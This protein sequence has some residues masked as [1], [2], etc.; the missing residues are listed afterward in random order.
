MTDI[1]LQTVSTIDAIR[2]MI[3]QDIYSLHFLPGDKIVES[4]LARRYGVSRNTLREAV[5]FLQASGILMKVPNK[6]V[7]V[8]KISISDVQQIFNLRALLECEAIKEIISGNKDT[9]ILN[10]CASN[11]E[12]QN[13][14]GEWHDSMNADIEFH[15]ML[16]RLSEN[17]R[18]QRLYDCV[19]PE[20]KL[21]IFQSKTFSTINPENAKQHRLLINYI[22][23]RAIDKAQNILM[24]HINSA[25]DGYV[26]GLLNQTRV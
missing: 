12:I 18:L 15:E 24:Y 5:A 14:L 20:V 16:I 7:F 21:C 19:L 8:K 26:L 22:E 9:S 23:Q 4:D 2:Q 11:V 25:V 17:E 1:Q 13:E 6:G 10:K 3:E